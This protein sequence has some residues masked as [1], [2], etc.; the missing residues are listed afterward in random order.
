MFLLLK[1][2][3]ARPPDYT[4]THTAVGNPMFFYLVKKF[5]W[6]KFATSIEKN[7]EILEINIEK[8]HK[9]FTLKQRESIDAK[10]LF[11]F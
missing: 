4:H 9:F 11:S 8:L 5:G 6:L 10:S 3:T 2:R 7:L 1:Y